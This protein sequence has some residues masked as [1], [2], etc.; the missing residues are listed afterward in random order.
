M[1]KFF[2][3]RSGFSVKNYYYYVPSDT[4]LHDIGLASYTRNSLVNFGK[5]KAR[6]PNA[7]WQWHPDI[8]E[9][10]G[11][12]IGNLQ[13]ILLGD[14]AVVHMQRFDKDGKRY[15][16]TTSDGQEENNIFWTP[17][18]TTGSEGGGI[19]FTQLKIFQNKF[20]LYQKGF[21]KADS[22]L[23][24]EKLDAYNVKYIWSKII[25]SREGCL[26]FSAAGYNVLGLA[27]SGDI[28][29]F[30]QSKSDG[31]DRSVALQPPVIAGVARTATGKEH[32][33]AISETLPIGAFS[34]PDVGGIKNPNNTVAGPLK[35]SFNRG[36]GEWESGTT[37]VYCRLLDDIAG[38]SLDDLPEN[39]DL[40][41]NESLKIPTAS[42]WGMLLQTEKGNP[43]LL[44]P[45]SFG[46]AT[47]SKERIL[48]INRSTRAFTK[49]EIVIASQ[50]NGDYVPIPLANGVSVAK[51]LTIEWSQIQ[52]YIVNAKGF[53]RND[54]DTS[55][56]EPQDYIAAVRAKFYDSLT[57]ATYAPLVS[58][59]QYNIIPRLR[60]WNL[61]TMDDA[62]YSLNTNGSVQDPSSSEVNDAVTI[63]NR[64][65]SI[66]PN[67]FNYHTFYDADMLP[68]DIGGNNSS[69]TKLKNT[70]I[71]RTTPYSDTMG[72]AAED[73]PTSWGMYFPDGYSSLSVR[74]TKSTR[75]VSQVASSNGRVVYQG[76]TLNFTPY[77]NLVGTTFNLKDS[78][79][80][81][82]PAQIALN[83]SGNQSID[84][85]FMMSAYYGN[86]CDSYVQYLHQQIKG[87]YL[88]NSSNKPAY[89]LTPINST[90]VQFT[91]LSLEL[92]LSTT[93]IDNFGLGAQTALNEGYSDLKLALQRAGTYGGDYFGGA[94]SRIGIN[95]AVNLEPD[96]S[97]RAKLSFAN[98]LIN[99][100]IQ[101]PTAA[102][103]IGPPA[104]GDKPDGGPEMI[105]MVNAVE[106]SNVIGILA[107]KGTF[108]MTK[109]GIVEFKTNQYLG[110]LTYTTYTISQTNISI[111]PIL[112]FAQDLSGRSMGV[113]HIKWG[114]SLGAEQVKELGTTA[115]WCAVYDHSP[116][117][118][119]DGRFFAPL[120][121]NPSGAEMDFEE[122][123]LQTGTILT[124]GS[125]KFDT[126]KN[127]VRRNMLLS[128]GG[129]AYAQKYIGLD[130]TS[131]KINKP[132][133]GYADFDKVK[134]NIGGKPAH[135]VVTGL[136]NNGGISQLSIDEELLKSIDVGPG[137]IYGETANNGTVNPFKYGPTANATIQSVNGTGAEIVFTRGKVYE[138]LKV[139]KS[140]FYGIKK[141][142]HEDN[143]GEGNSKGFITGTKTTTFTL[144]PNSTGKYDVFFFFVS[145]IANYPEGGVIF[146]EGSDV[147]AA[148]YVEL[149][150]TST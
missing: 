100:A 70:V 16:D 92:A 2:D 123:F 95:N 109:G 96:G 121:F 144:E 86:T 34:A 36:T 18:G 5:T 125:P 44:A 62:D 105:P 74:R 150:I 49:G 46:C 146:G 115:L 136:T 35:V 11:T 27:A 54:S 33:F 83:S 145:D 15:L 7:Q 79:F 73:V 23:L 13:N 64:N 93:Q 119:Y 97:V 114:G 19:A 138:R 57:S 108:P 50:I 101:N 43:H 124:S 132:G 148:R 24:T 88:N 120:Q 127:K 40:V 116:N 21:I 60:E 68:K 89:G 111:S 118:I 78:Y 81:H 26:T 37:Q 65:K 82:L 75:S 103:N 76:G 12:S 84:P 98:K 133:T 30:F 17:S 130:T 53:F 48:L 143:N 59:L 91:P 131:I 3:S 14:S 104:R 45:V 28:K 39:V 113:E 42:G 77:T 128:D 69:P 129:F 63:A 6:T 135:L 61:V 142:T 25:N 126:I 55:F 85:V 112:G 149:E 141:L 72:V 99:Y 110:L 29:I 71:K 102:I 41:D 8:Q 107:A 80:Y 9:F 47:S 10:F 52:K 38:V 58:G 4:K 22:T 1:T 147:P 139:D 106:S 134:V 94:W 87:Y 140:Q 66:L 122:V 20:D 67:F 56:I 32:A 137:Y 90:F 31:S 117:T 51:K